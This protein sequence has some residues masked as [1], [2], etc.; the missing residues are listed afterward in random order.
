MQAFLLQRACDTGPMS[1]LKIVTPF[2]LSNNVFL[3]VEANHGK[4]QPWGLVLILPQELSSCAWGFWWKVLGLC[5]CW[6]CRP[7]AWGRGLATR[8]RALVL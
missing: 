2:K 3:W 8:L 6:A 7:D 1:H 4:S 5:D